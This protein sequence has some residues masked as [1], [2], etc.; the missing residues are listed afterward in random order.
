MV[1]F[2]AEGQDQPERDEYPHRNPGRAGVAKNA[3]QREAKQTAQER[4]T[5]HRFIPRCSSPTQNSLRSRDTVYDQEKRALRLTLSGAAVQ[6]CPSGPSLA[7]KRSLEPPDERVAERVST[8]DA[9]LEHYE[10]IS[11]LYQAHYGDLWSRRY[12]DAFI[13]RLL[14]DGLDLRGQRVLDAMCGS[15]ETTE[16]LL[17]HEDHEFHGCVI[18]VIQE[19][20]EALGARDRRTRLGG[21]QIGCDLAYMVESIER[22]NG[23]IRKQLG[24]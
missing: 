10:R 24:M 17:E 5:A 8:E 18:V 15:G 9:Q 14:F 6:V 3:V 11:E 12:R 1:E 4:P 21:D 23:E 19:H 22:I 20:L 2:L 16:Y 7:T 13:N